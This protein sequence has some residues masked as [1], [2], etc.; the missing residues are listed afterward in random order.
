MGCKD[1][2]PQRP[3]IAGRT[4][5]FNTA[6][7]PAAP[8]RF[9]PP[10]VRWSPGGKA[11][12][13][14][15][16]APG[17]NIPPVSWGGRAP[18]HAAAQLQSART[19][20]PPP[21]RWARGVPPGVAH[22]A[23]QPQSARTPSPPPV[24]WARSAP[25]GVVHAAVQ[26]QTARAP[27]PPPVR[28]ARGAP[29]GVAHAAVQ[30]AL[31]QRKPAWPP[32]ALPRVGIV[33]KAAIFSYLLP[34]AATSEPAEFTGIIGQDNETLYGRHGKAG[35]VARHDQQHGGDVERAVEMTQAAILI[36]NASIVGRQAHALVTE[37]FKLDLADDEQLEAAKKLKTG[38]ER[39]LAF[40][41][42][43]KSVFIPDVSYPV[44]DAAAESRK[45]WWGLGS[46]RTN[47]A[48]YPLQICDLDANRR[49]TTLV[50]EASHHVL[51]TTDSHFVKDSRGRDVHRAVYV[52]GAP[53]AEPTPPRADWV[54]LS[55][56]SRAINADTLAHFA[57]AAGAGLE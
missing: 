49:A 41:K 52:Y 42:E 18:Q 5:S 15:K 32:G 53:S 7:A 3:A 12:V 30:S 8:P 34:Q 21:V 28:W 39:M 31:A 57:A 22:A 50:H 23:V 16:P 37:W 20:P 55:R 29:P 43:K 19:L 51:D 27:S 13:Q 9:A 36:L 26:P 1:G 6:A 40:F 4:I 47:I 45:S 10:P 33:Q 14:P 38:Y 48:L 44:K 11:L 46:E 2:A 25:P 35:L 24:R 17:P 54:S 56:Q